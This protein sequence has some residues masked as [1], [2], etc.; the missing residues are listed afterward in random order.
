MLG[1]RTIPIRVVLAARSLGVLTTGFAAQGAYLDQGPTQLGKAPSQ[2][3]PVT[4]VIRPRAEVEMVCRLCSSSGAPE[5]R[6][7]GCYRR[8][9]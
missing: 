4:V 3:G 7:H 5:G 1:M 2:V 9:G 6:I 8:I